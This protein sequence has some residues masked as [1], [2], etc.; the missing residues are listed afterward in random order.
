MLSGSSSNT[1]LTRADD[2]LYYKG[3]FPPS[4]WRSQSKYTS[5]QI[6]KPTKLFPKIFNGFIPIQSKNKTL[7]NFSIIPLRIWRDSAG[8]VLGK[9]SLAKGIPSSIAALIKISTIYA[10]SIPFMRHRKA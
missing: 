6:E 5:K 8:R 4:L 1:G 10:I 3:K 9:N 2:G 7:P